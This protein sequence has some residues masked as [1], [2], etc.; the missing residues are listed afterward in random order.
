MYLLP[1][2]ALDCMF[3]VYKSI[4]SPSLLWLPSKKSVENAVCT[5]TCMLTCMYMLVSTCMRE[6]HVTSHP[7]EDPDADDRV[8]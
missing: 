5:C 6:Q 4:K 8:I 3:H 7:D 1:Y 2:N